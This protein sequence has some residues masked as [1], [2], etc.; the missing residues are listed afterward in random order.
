M[1]AGDQPRMR[2]GSL[3]G[4]GCEDDQGGLGSASF[5]R[6]GLFGA[7]FALSPPGFL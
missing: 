4:R 2:R 3:L 7:R 5:G 6:M 1:E